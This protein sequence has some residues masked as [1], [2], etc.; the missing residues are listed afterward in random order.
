M[1]GTVN[2]TAAREGTTPPRTSVPRHR[3]VGELMTRQVYAIEPDADFRAALAALRETGHQDLPV[4]DGQGRAMG[5]VCAP[6]LLAKL[7]ATALPQ[8]SV[9]ET[10][11][12]RDIRR[13]AAAVTVA[14]LM[15]TPVRSVTAQDTA[16]EAALLALRHR[17]HQLP[18]VDEHHRLV[19]VVTV[20]DLLDALRRTDAEIEA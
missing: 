15:T 4:V 2:R 16:A 1:T 10:R 12:T 5:I 20:N 8:P 18:V 19:G 3:L 7:A 11:R 17:I 14:E 13:R 6:D 9:F